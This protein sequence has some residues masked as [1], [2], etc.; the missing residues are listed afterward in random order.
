MDDGWS[1]QPDLGMAIEKR[2]SGVP[3]VSL[4]HEPDLVNETSLDPRIALQ[5]SATP[6]A[7]RCLLPG[8][9][10][11]FTPHLGKE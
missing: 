11:I 4:L 7:D 5:L 10:P 1:G 9:P 8:Q 3:I 6:T 2:P